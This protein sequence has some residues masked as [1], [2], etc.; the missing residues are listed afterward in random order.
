MAAID[1]GVSASLVHA[2]ESIALAPDVTGSVHLPGA[3]RDGI[4]SQLR[5]AAN[6]TQ[7]DEQRGAIIR[8]L[9]QQNTSMESFRVP[10]SF[11]V[12]GPN[13]KKQNTQV[14]RPGPFDL[15]T[16]SA[17]PDVGFYITLDYGESSF[18][19]LSSAPNATASFTRQVGSECYTLS[20][21]LPVTCLTCA[22]GY[23]PAAQAGCLN[24]G[25]RVVIGTQTFFISSIGD[26]NK[27]PGSSG[28]PH[29]HFAEGGEA[30]LRGKNHTYYA[31]L[32]APGVTF[33]AQT[34]DVSFLLPRPQLVH[35]SFF[36]HAA[37]TIRGTSGRTYGLRTAADRVGFEVVDVPSG[38]LIE[39]FTNIWRQWWND[40]IRAVYK[41]ST[42][43]VR[44]AGWEVNC[45]RHPVYNYVSGYGKWRFDI[46][47]RKLDGTVF[48]RRHNASSAT[49]Y[50]HGIIGQSYDGDHL[51]IG[52]AKD[53]YTYRAE[54]PVITTKAMAEGAIEGDASHYELRVGARRGF[55]LRAP[56]SPGHRQVRAPRCARARG[57][58]RPP[59]R[60]ARS[61]RAPTPSSRVAPPLLP[62][63]HPPL[64]SPLLPPSR[65]FFESA[66]GP[67]RKK[68]SIC[69]GNGDAI[70]RGRAYAEQSECPCRP[71]AERQAPH[72][73]GGLR[74]LRADRAA[75]RRAHVVRREPR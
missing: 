64:P 7:R 3:I 71:L 37:W 42:M 15:T 74:H 24:T 1:A 68:N 17:E 34:H 59:A 55:P 56:P 72:Q 61:R 28:D 57:P 65:F 47:M 16:L 6:T 23:V 33:A 60:T 10:A 8:V 66:I 9:F 30:D 45:T 39:K 22:H 54:S 48:A 27:G 53:D 36:T 5:N 21:P 19:T 29:L 11:L 41:Q 69:H 38:R 14:V 50:P 67:G 75:R 32:S 12:L 4:Q 51:G 20:S 58:A 52:G 44:A 63:F 13:Y 2:V 46:A 35:G 70:L 26:G 73:G 49:C 25:D 18:L 40:G 62:L 31:M 43:Y